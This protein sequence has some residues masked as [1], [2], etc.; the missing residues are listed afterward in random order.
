M[1][2]D[3]VPRDDYVMFARSLQTDAMLERVR[4][5]T[6]DTDNKIR[7]LEYVNVIV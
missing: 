4:R 7:Q 6:A 3:Y 2:L 5:V 1:S